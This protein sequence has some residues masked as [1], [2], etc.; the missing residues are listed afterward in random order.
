[1]Q[2][3]SVAPIQAPISLLEK[4]PA[5]LEL[6]LRDV[7]AEILQWKP[8]TD[9]WSIAEVLAHMT[10][11]E[12]LYEQRARRIVTE[13]APLLPKYVAPPEGEANIRAARGYL[14]EFVALRRAF[15]V[16]LHTLP[17]AAAARAGKH[18]ELREITLSQ[19]LHELA[20]HDLGHLRQI[21]E[22][23]RAKA[24]HPH[25]GPFQKYSNP[26]P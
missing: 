11:I 25:A 10:V 18:V 20:N 15:V 7:P 1:M 6:L 2:P 3:L 14:D 19:M 23:Y 13:N 26:K 4:T 9:R 16:F 22:L 21:A 24:F 12:K 8:A 5:L 17:S